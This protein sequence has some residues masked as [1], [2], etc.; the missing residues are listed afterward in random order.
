M[1][2]DATPEDKIF[3]HVFYVVIC[4]VGGGEKKASHL[5]HLEW[6]FLKLTKNYFITS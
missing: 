2:H 5:L 6:G 4:R 1:K 3:S